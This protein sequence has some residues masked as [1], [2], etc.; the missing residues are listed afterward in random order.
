MDRFNSDFIWSIYALQEQKFILLVLVTWPSWPPCPYGI[1]SLKIFYSRTISDDLETLHKAKWTWALQKFYKWWP[2]VDLDL[3]YNKVN[4]VHLGFYIGKVCPHF[5]T[6]FPQKPLDWLKF[7]L[8]IEHLC[9]MG[10]KVYIIGPG[11]MTK[12][13]NMPIYGNNPLKIFFSRTMSDD[14]RLGTQ[15]KG[16]QPYNSCIND[17]T[18]LTLTILQGQ[19]CSFRLLLW[20]SLS[21]L[22]NS[23]SSETTGLIE[24]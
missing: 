15:Q 23:F 10:T 18:E 24:I 20:K 17:D 9:L 21:T 14:L 1:N 6:S 12:M 5:Q 19:L 8:Y 22:S 7:R 2:L 3:F 16:F 4:F 11:H 13:A